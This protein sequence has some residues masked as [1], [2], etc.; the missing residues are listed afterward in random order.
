MKIN[1]VM[2]VTFEKDEVDKD[3]DVNTRYTTAHFR[4]KSKLI[5]NED[6][7]VNKLKEINASIETR[8]ADW[9]LQGSNWTI[10]S[11]DALELNVAKYYSAFKGSSYL[12]IPL[13]KEISNPKKGLIKT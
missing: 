1:E 8:I 6:E 10:S 13:P 9:I 7:I 2:T 11:I 5:T 12:Y 4:N 3:G